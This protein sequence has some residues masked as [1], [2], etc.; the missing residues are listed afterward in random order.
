MRLVATYDM[1]YGRKGP[2]DAEAPLVLRGEEFEVH[3]TSIASADEVA[4]FMTRAGAAATPDAWSKRKKVSDMN[5]TW[6]SGEC[7][8]AR[9]ANL[10]RKTGRGA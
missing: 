10:N 3:S 5:A 6:A 1:H 4:G 9:E 2:N 7:A 8:K